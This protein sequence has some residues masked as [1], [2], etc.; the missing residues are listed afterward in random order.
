MLARLHLRLQVVLQPDLVDQVQLRF[1]VLDMFLG[2]GEDIDQNF[3]A[4]VIP[5]R[6]AIGDAFLDGGVRGLFQLQV[7]LEHLGGILAEQQLVQVLQV[8]QAVQHQDALDQAV[9]VLHFADRFLV[10]HLAELLQA[11]VAIHAG[12]QEI[13]VDRGQLVLELGVEML[14][15]LLVTFHWRLLLHRARAKIRNGANGAVQSQ[16]RNAQKR[17][18]N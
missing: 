12:V 18:V 15:D 4:D 1:Q 11:P 14:D 13:L 3:A 9:G 6:F 10:L 16:K 7:A 2:I 5:D 8:G 17:A